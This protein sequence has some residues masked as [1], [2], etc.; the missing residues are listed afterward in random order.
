MLHDDEIALREIGLGPD[1]AVLLERIEVERGGSRDFCRDVDRRASGHDDAAG[2][3]AE[4]DHALAA[5]PSTRDG[6]ST[7]S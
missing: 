2:L 5:R 1:A 7:A 6:G 4:P 3:L